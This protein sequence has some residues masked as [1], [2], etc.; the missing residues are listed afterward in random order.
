MGDGIVNA[1]TVTKLRPVVAG[2][3]GSSIWNILFQAKKKKKN[4]P[5]M[6]ALKTNVKTYTLNI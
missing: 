6:Y 2:Q 1:S 5:K 3:Q 4:T